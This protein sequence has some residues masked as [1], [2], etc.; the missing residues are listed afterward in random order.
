M[1]DRAIGRISRA[2]VG[3]QSVAPV[4]GSECVFPGC[5]CLTFAKFRVHRYAGTARNNLVSPR[6]NR[7]PDHLGQRPADRSAQGHSY[8]GSGRK[9]DVARVLVEET[10]RDEEQ[11]MRALPDSAVFWHRSFP[12]KL[13]DIIVDNIRAE[14][15]VC[16]S[17]DCWRFAIIALAQSCRRAA[18]RAQS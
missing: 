14:R 12:N 11:V 4:R 5:V 7:C 3:L 8:G 9:R 18:T 16:Y 13:S 1:T 10:A 6:S 17:W 15:Q 2:G